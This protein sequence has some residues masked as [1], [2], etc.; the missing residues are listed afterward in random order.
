MRIGC[1]WNSTTFS[2]IKLLRHL[3]NFSMSILCLFLKTGGSVQIW[4]HFLLFHEQ[5]SNLKKKI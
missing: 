4:F 5:I 1:D 3:D 2:F